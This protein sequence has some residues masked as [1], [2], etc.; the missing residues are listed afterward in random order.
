MVF[1]SNRIL[2]LKNDE[3]CPLNG[4]GIS[5]TED[6]PK[7]EGYEKKEVFYSN[8]DTVYYLYYTNNNP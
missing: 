6:D 8:D 2:C 7:Y 1:W 5:I 3:D 4:F